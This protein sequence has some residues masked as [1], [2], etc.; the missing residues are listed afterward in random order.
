MNDVFYGGKFDYFSQIDGW[1][2]SKSLAVVFHFPHCFAQ[3]YKINSI[4]H[5]I[6]KKTHT[7]ISMEK[8][9]FSLKR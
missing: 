2:F 9:G 4:Y 6:F 1:I 7:Q 8:K 5:L 3:R